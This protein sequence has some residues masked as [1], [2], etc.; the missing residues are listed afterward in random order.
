MVELNQLGRGNRKVKKSEIQAQV[1]IF[2]METGRDEYITFLL[3][4][5]GRRDGKG[6]SQLQLT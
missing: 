1:Q 4:G 2:Q 3:E 5:F 6:F